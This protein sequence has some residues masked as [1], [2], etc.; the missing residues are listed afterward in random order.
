MAD[1]KIS[2]LPSLASATS[3]DLL[4]IVNDPGGSPQTDKITASAFLGSFPLSSAAVTNS[5]QLASVISDETGSGQLVFSTS[6]TL[7]TPSIAS[8]TNATHNHLTNAGGGLITAAAVSDFNTQVRTNRLD[9][10]AAPGANV[11]MASF[12]LTNLLDPTNAQDAA[13][14]SYADAIASGLNTK[15]SCRLATTANLTGTYVGSPTFTLTETGSGALSVD[16]TTP[17]IGDR[18]L[19]KN[20]TTGTQNGIYTVTDVGS[21]GTS[22][23]LTR[24]T[25]F[26]SSADIASGDYT[27]VTS[28]TVNGATG[29]ILVTANPITIDVT[30]LTFTQFSSAT[31]YTAGNGLV[32]TGLSFAVGAGTGILATAGTTAVDTT[33]VATTSNSLTM[34]NKT[35]VAPVLGAATATSINKVTITAP[36][37]SATLTIADGKI[38][39]ATN[40]ITLGGTDGKT[41]TVSN[42]LALAGTDGK[43]LTVNASLTLAGTDSTVMTFP[44]T[45]GSVTTADV[46][47][48]LTNKTIQNGSYTGTLPLVAV[49]TAVTSGSTATGLSY[50]AGAHTTLTASTEVIDVALTLARTV[51]WSTGSLTLQRAVYISAPTYAFV[52]ASTLTTAITLDVDAPVAGTNATITNTLAARFNGTLQV[53]T[54]SDAIR[55]A[56][57][58]TI[59]V[60]ASNLGMTLKGNATASAAGSDIIA[61]ST[62]TRTAGNLMAIQNNGVNQLIVG[63]AGQVSIQGTAQTSGTVFQLAIKTSNHT[64]QTLSTE[65]SNV[66]YVTYTRQWATG[67]ITNQ[68][69][70]SFAA[71]TYAFVGASTITNAATMYISAAPIAGTNATI[72]NS[73]SFWVDA[74][75]A[76]FDGDGTRVFEIGLSDTTALGAFYGRIPVLI[77]GVGT[78]YIAM[79]N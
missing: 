33:V 7:T 15:A 26:D 59:R 66:Q 30:S 67:A 20:Q 64:N 36:A 29:F 52:G 51:Q 1:V 22:W 63:Y 47:Q 3:D 56:T 53:S 4:V 48:T 46:S 41:L 32:L 73:Y 37:T 8:F 34:S 19:L 68:R 13:T 28:G 23:V 27:F 44:S 12:K 17:S 16:G 24:A 18:I 79:Y 42:S 21:G 25:D 14:K 39:S 9:Q 77:P 54:S 76:R 2:A 78:R 65:I 10:M 71:P 58:A 55:L 69:E 50:A 31:A 43:S 49:Q 61:T 38:L 75:L 40:S 5:S 70:I 62:A 35:F 45:S 60:T 6:P 74:G 72:T 11:S 57:T